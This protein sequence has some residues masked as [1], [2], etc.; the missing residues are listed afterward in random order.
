MIFKRDKSNI[1]LALFAAFFLLTIGAC[2]EDDPGPEDPAPSIQKA[3]GF[4]IV[5]EGTFNFGNASIS[6]Y[7]FETEEVTPG[8]FKSANGH[9]PGDVLQDMYVHEG[10]GYLVLNNSGFV[11][12]VDIET[13]VSEGI[14]SPL[15][16]PRNFLPVSEDKAYV[17]DLYAN[18]IQI[19]DMPSREVAGSIA[20]PFWT[21]QMA[22]ADQKVFVSSPWDVRLDP[23]DHIYIVDPENDLLQDSIQVGVD[24]TALVLD[25]E[26]K[27]W[28]FC[29]GS[30][31][32]EAPAALVCVNTQTMEVERSLTFEDYDLGFATR[33]AINAS[34]DTLYFLKNDVFA[35]P[36]SDSSLPE[37][38]IIPSDGRNLYALGV[39]P[40]NGDVLIG[41]AI[42]YAQQGKVYLYD[43]QGELKQVIDAG[44][45]PSRFVFY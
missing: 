24:P 9:T 29:R 27:L 19:V 7:R 22:V 37:N 21:E 17:S 16:S 26:T 34:G 18:S 36:L 23:H 32:Q 1:S 39:N 10:K 30:E 20:M 15:E 35:F 8:V 28:V 5:N 14:I 11:E 12:V 42:D 13:F 40:V 3:E 25:G 4:F 38:P 41:D 44:V 31:E 2:Q 33:L 43:S 6:Y 45:I